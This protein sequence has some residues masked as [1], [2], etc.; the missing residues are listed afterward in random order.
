MLSISI[1]AIIMIS[2][3]NMAPPMPINFEYA[4]RVI[5]DD[6]LDRTGWLP[7]VLVTAEPIT[8]S[9]EKILPS[10]SLDK[11]TDHTYWLPEVVV[12]AEPIRDSQPVNTSGTVLPAT[13]RLASVVLVGVLALFSTLLGFGLLARPEVPAGSRLQP[14]CVKSLKSS[15]RRRTARHRP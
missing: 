1:A 13:G 6:G 7:E 5:A 2:S 10:T 4:H 14:A 9:T 11:G 8:A 3:G 12:T 15:P